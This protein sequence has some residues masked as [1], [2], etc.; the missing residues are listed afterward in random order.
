MISFVRSLVAIGCAFRSAS[1]SP[2]QL[3]G[4][5]TCSL[6]KVLCCDGLNAGLEICGNK[7]KC[8]I[9]NSVFGGNKFS[10]VEMFCFL[11]FCCS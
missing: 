8:S 10:G 11:L 4:A 1:S 6:D 7:V 2:I 9:S 3:E 5:A